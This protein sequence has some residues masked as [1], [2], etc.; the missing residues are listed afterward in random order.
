MKYISIFERI[1]RSRVKDCFFVKELLMFIVKENEIGKAI[2]KKG[3]NVKMVEKALN[4]KIK[5]VEFSPKMD[6]FLKNLLYPTQVKGITEQEGVVTI[7]GID[8][9]G[10]SIIIGR[11]SSNL[12]NTK[13]IIKRYFEIDNIKVV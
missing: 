7:E 6:V 12:N 4:R 9:S 2:G 5:I 13:E 1:T 10:K 8:K 11:D 3:I